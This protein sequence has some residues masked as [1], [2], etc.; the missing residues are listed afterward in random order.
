ML[1]WV[2]GFLLCP[3]CSERCFGVINSV[4]EVQVVCVVLELIE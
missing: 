3:L 2:R 1:P 4:S